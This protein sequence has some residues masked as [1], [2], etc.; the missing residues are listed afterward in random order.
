LT[1][2]AT[3]LVLVGLTACEKEDTTVTNPPAPGAPAPRDSER[4]RPGLNQEAPAGAPGNPT[5]P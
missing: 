1:A 4:A 5:S 2:M 3:T